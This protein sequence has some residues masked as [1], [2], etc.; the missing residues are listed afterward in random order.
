LI[1]VVENEIIGCPMPHANSLQPA[2]SP[3]LQRLRRHLGPRY[4]EFQHPN[5]PP[6]SL[7]EIDQELKKALSSRRISGLDALRA[8]AVSLVFIDHFRVIDYFLGVHLELGW[9]GVMIFFVLSGFLITSMLLKEHSK[10]GLISLTSFYR[11][12]AYRIFPTFYCCWILT[13][14]VQ[15]LAHRFYWKTA[16][17][18]FFY[19]MDYGRALA[20][21]NMQQY[22]HMWI[23]WSLAVEEKFYL[24]W[25]LLLSFLLKRRPKLIRVMAAIILAQWTYRAT[26]Y[27]GFNVN[28]AYVYSTFDMRLDALLVGC[29]LGILVENDRTRLQCCRLLRQQSMSVLPP[30]AL[31]VMAISPPTNKAAFLASWSLQPL[32]IAVL[33]LQTAYWGSRS[34]A[35][36][37]SGV[38]R[39]TACLSYSLYLYHPLAGQIVYVLHMRHL[40]YYAISLTLL[41]AAASYHLVERPFMRLR[42]RGASS[43]GVINQI[44][45]F[46]QPARSAPG[47]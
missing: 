31:I 37:R 34:W 11:R 29:L 12:R 1:L 10:T 17:V 19:L 26:L 39:V 4:R 27:I 20:P 2:H 5:E 18:S 21:E 36:C 8:L 47:K 32:I 13:T 43:Q 3:L 14:A 42:D 33:L 45:A 9:F 15:C 23:S 28:W 22:L 46:H 40:G 24:L 25:P 44:G 16:A 38:V 6:I 41:M 30:L 35:F 7:Q